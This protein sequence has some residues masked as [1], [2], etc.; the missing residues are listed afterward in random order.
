[1]GHILDILWTY[2]GYIW[3]VK[4]TFIYFTG[5]HN[6]RD[7]LGTQFFNQVEPML[8][9][10][11]T[12]L[13]TEKHC[14]PFSQQKG[15]LLINFLIFYA[16]YWEAGLSQGDWASHREG[17]PSLGGRASHKGAGLLTGRPCLSQ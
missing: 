2:L 10:V 15:H 5:Y 3:V 12:F 16:S 7:G 1:M 9:C 14:K 4:V 13:K 11:N 8:V 17:G 6:L